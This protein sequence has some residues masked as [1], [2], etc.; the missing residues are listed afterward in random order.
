MDAK[1]RSSEWKAVLAKLGGGSPGSDENVQLAGLLSAVAFPATRDE[2]LAGLAP[3][4]EFRVR[5]VSVDLREAVSES[6]YTAFASMYA[7]IDC[8]KDAL[9]RAERL[10]H[11]QG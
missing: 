6:P 4:S 8:V 10:E 11:S 5:S 7:I 9:R 3:G 2:A 1:N